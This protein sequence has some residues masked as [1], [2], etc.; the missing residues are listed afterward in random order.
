M[1]QHIKE[2]NTT[3]KDIIRVLKTRII[4]RSPSYPKTTSHYNGNNRSPQQVQLYV[5]EQE[6]A[7]SSH[8]STQPTELK[9]RYLLN[10]ESSSV[11]SY[12]SYQDNNRYCENYSNTLYPNEIKNFKDHLPEGT[13]LIKYIN[14]VKVNLF[15]LCLFNS[16]ST[17]I[18]LNLRALPPGITPTVGDSQSFTTTQ[19]TYSSNEIIVGSEIFFP[20]FC[21]YRT[22]SELTFRLF[23][24]VQ[25]PDMMSS[26]VEMFYRAVLSSTTDRTQ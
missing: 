12:Y 8:S 17:C 1:V 20:K 22:I 19:G 9:N 14:G 24:I 7:T 11:C 18:L 6:S 2:R 23:I 25:I 15:G 26:S 13:M 3:F 21:Q 10:Q 5:N 4:K 16:G